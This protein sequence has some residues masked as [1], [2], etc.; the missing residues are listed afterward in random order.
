MQLRNDGSTELNK[1]F[2]AAMPFFTLI[3]A[4]STDFFY[5]SEKSALISVEVCL[6][7]PHFP[8]P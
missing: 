5:K 3:N 7:M 8:A 2:I 1:N 6:T 4:D